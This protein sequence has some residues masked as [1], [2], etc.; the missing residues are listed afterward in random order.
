MTAQVKNPCGGPTP[1]VQV[2]RMAFGEFLMDICDKHILQFGHKACRNREY[3]PG[4]LQEKTTKQKRRRY[5][6]GAELLLQRKRG[7]EMGKAEAFH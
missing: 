1:F 2:W 6:G 7:V 4:T 5:M 3:R